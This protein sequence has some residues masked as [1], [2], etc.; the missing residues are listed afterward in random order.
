M[1][2]KIKNILSRP[3]E[4]DLAAQNLTID[5]GWRGE[6]LCVWALASTPRSLVE[7]EGEKLGV[8]PRILKRSQKIFKE[9]KI[10]LTGK[11]EKKIAQPNENGPA[12]QNLTIDFGWR[13]DILCAWN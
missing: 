1:C 11:I 5:F 7:K 4:D 10:F 2:S 13:G 12:A 3:Y 6:I 8:Q 9:M